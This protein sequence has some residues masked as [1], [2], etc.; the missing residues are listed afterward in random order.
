MRP[1]FKESTSSDTDVFNVQTTGLFV[2]IRLPRARRAVFNAIRA[3]GC[4]SL[5]HCSLDELRA[6]ARQHTFAGFSKIA[7][8]SDV[9]YRHHCIDWN[10]HPDFAR[11]RPNAWRFQLSADKNS[12]K[13]FS[14]ASDEFNQ[15]VYM[16]RWQRLSGGKSGT[17]ALR[18]RPTAK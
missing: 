6:L 4:R 9:C 10:Y 15:A 1:G 3:R 12:F 18:R 7:V 17:L 14:V 11:P 16:E 2:D 8:N 13:E 5:Q